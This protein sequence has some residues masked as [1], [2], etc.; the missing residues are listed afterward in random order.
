MTQVNINQLTDE[1]LN[2][3]LE[4]R[5]NEIARRKL[6][7]KRWREN[8]PDKVKEC[9]DNYRAKKKLREKAIQD[10]AVERGKGRYDENGK[11]HRIK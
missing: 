5:D 8:N 11:F 1:Q 2:E 3:L 10:L 6:S 4:R 7:A 9:V